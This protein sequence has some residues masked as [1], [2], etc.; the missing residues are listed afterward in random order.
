MPSN[1]PTTSAR[2]VNSRISVPAAIKGS[3]AGVRMAGESRSVGIAGVF[4]GSETL[5]ETINRKPRKKKPARS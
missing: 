4:A 3:G 1:V 5:G 2:T